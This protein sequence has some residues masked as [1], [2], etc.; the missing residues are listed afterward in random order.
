MRWRASGTYSLS[1]KRRI[2]SWNV[3]NERSV[4]FGGRSDRSTRSSFSMMFGA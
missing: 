1:G 4:S 3:E 2:S